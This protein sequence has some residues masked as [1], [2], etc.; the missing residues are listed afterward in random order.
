MYQ[1][2]RNYKIIIFLA[3]INLWSLNASAQE[4]KEELGSGAFSSYDKVFNGNV[5]EINLDDYADGPHFF[6]LDSTIVKSW[7]IN[8]E[9]EGNTIDIREKKIKVKGDSVL[10]KGQKGDSNRYW[11]RKGKYPVQS[12]E[13]SGVNKLLAIGDVHGE[14]DVL[15]ELLQ[16]SGVIDENLD[17]KW[18]DGHLVF[19]G[20]IFDRGDKVTESLYLIKKLQRQ[21]NENKGKLHLLLGNHEVMVLMN[22][23]RYI[24]PK[25]KNMCQRLMMNYPRFFAENTELGKWLRS[26]NSVV[27]INDMLFVHGGLSPD[28]VD[29]GLSIEQINDDIRKSLN[30]DNEMTHEEL[31]KAVYFPENPLWYRGYLMKSRSYSIINTE[32]LNKVLSYYNTNRIFFGHTEVE[33]I[34]FLHEGKV[35]AINVPMGYSEI[36][37]QVLLVE[38]GRFYRCF[39]DGSKELIE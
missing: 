17:W 6:W 11:L 22:D 20:D 9:K 32:E 27:K 26:L 13:Y 23:S 24:A 31:M 21:A 28:L 10:V 5:K 29:R 2:I 30:K 3:A 35:G 16:N 36:K 1:P 4:K 34:R 38:E 12:A 19:I 39:I 18:G 14:Y 8:H 25:Y 7:Y 33:S 15:V 37:P